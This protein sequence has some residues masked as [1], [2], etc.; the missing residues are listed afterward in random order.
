MFVGQERKIV[1]R[2]L[3]DLRL[4]LTELQQEKTAVEESLG[5]QLTQL[6]ERLLAEQRDKA[7]LIRQLEEA[8]NEIS[9]EQ[10]A[11]L[12]MR[13]YGYASFFSCFGTSKG[14]TWSRT[15]NEGRGAYLNLAELTYTCVMNLGNGCPYSSGR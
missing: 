15:T 6:N 5:L 13:Y 2:S 1:E 3:E 9:N 14:R 7:N 4:R 8:K 10:H 12:C 11:I